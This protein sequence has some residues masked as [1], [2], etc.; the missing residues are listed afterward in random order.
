MHKYSATS[1]SAGRVGWVDYAKGIC[2]IWVVTMYATDYVKEVTHSIGWMQH[3]V[4]FAQPFRMPDF[5]LLSGLFVA[6]V[7]D[8]PWRS[9]LDT[10]VVHFLYFYVLWATLKFLN[11]YGKSLFGADALMLLPEYFSMFVEPPT[12]PLW[13]IY[14][15]ALFFL[16][17]RALRSTSPLIVL[18]LAMCL[19][20]AVTWGP[21]MVWSV[22]VADKFARY[23]VFF[24]SGYLL[25]GP[26]FAAAMR[27]Q[28]RRGIAVAVLAFW[29]IA[30]Q[31]MVSLHLTFLPGMQ[32]ILGYVGAGGVMLAATLL[33]RADYTAWLRYLGQHSIVVYLG[34]VVPL[35]M[36][37][38]LLDHP[39]AMLDLGSLSFI[40]MVLSIA[41]AILMYWAV[42]RTPLRFLFERPAWARIT[43]KK[44]VEP[45]TEKAE[46]VRSPVQ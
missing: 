46:A 44:Q 27:A 34:F 35:G 43:E 19:Q 45:K 33:A 36:M 16:A 6:R 17:V 9:Y 18:P 42:R 12:G 23:F 14:V 10:K 26:I 25:A 11:I 4:N 41:G 28:S 7:L 1:A 24:Y 15:L 13:F 22:K 8:R 2:I 29:A 40:V 5:F 31:V 21:D 20:I 3:A 38:K 39:P 30:N 37:R 32:L